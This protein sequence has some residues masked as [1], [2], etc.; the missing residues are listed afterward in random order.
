MFFTIVDLEK[1]CVP[2]DLVNLC[3]RRRGVPGK[4]VR[5]VDATY[6]GVSTVVRT[7]H[8]RTDEFPIIKVGLHQGSRLS[9]LQCIVV[10]DVFSEEF[11][12]GLPCELLFADDLAVV[13]DTEEEMQRRLLGWQVGMERRGLKV[14]TGK[15]E[16]MVSSRRGTKANIKDSQGTT[17]RQMNKFKYLAVTISE[18]GGSEEA[19]RARVSAAWGKWRDLSRIISDE[20]MPRKLKIKLYMTVIRPVLLYGTEYWTVRKKEEHSLEKTD[21]RMLRRIKGVTLIRNKV[22]CEHQKGAKS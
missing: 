4:L 22:E 3:L 17:L 8:G 9:P 5:L 15:T 16:V 1:A 20:K 10:L 18:E 12:C 7:T 21:M 11:R 13:T 19:V 14:N 6:H 2:W